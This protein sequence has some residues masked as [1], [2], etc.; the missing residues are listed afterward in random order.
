MVEPVG[1]DLQSIPETPVD[2]SAEPERTVLVFGVWLG[3]ATGLLEVVLLFVRRHLLD[4]SAVSALE[5]NQ[6]ARWMIPISHAMIFGSLRA[7]SCG[8][9]P[10]LTRSRRLVDLGVYGL[11][12]LSCLPG[13]AG[14]D[15]H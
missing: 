9:S 2:M 15:R 1:F 7:R 14:L 8:H 11:C 3:L 6:H 13:G 10:S 12:F 4:S 5:L